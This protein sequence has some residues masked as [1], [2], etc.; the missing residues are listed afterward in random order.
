MGN[1]SYMWIKL[2]LYEEHVKSY[3]KAMKSEKTPTV[4]DECLIKDVSWP[5]ALINHKRI[6]KVS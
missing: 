2:P 5:L 4:S 3:Y 6:I 1:M